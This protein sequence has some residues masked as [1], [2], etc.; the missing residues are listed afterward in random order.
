MSFQ[1]S[2]T[3]SPETKKRDII[4]RFVSRQTKNSVM[5]N[6]KKDVH[7]H[8][9]STNIIKKKATKLAFEARQLVTKGKV[10]STWTRNCKVFIKT[11]GETPEDQEVLLIKSMADALELQNV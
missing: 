11:E 1:Q 10:A 2:I 7:I 8:Y 5:K 3:L 9:T 4:V 6:R